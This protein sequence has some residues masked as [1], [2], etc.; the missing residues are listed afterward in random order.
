MNWVLKVTTYH[1]K[2]SIKIIKDKTA[3]ACTLVIKGE[4]IIALAWTKVQVR[5][6]L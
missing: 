6:K 5:E 1:N 2:T 3:K 4:K